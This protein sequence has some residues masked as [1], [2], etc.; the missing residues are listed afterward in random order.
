[1]VFRQQHFD[2][3]QISALFGQLSLLLRSGLSVPD[4][5]ALL[6][7]D[8]APLQQSVCRRMLT[9][10]ESAEN[11]ATAMRQCD[12][13]PEYACQMVSLSELSGNTDDVLEALSEHYAREAEIAESLRSAVIYPAVMICM[14]AAV[15]AVI[16]TKVLPV[17]D[18]VFAQMGGGLTG[19]SYRLLQFGQRLEQSA[20]LL[21]LL[22]LLLMCTIIL[23][24]KTP[25]FHPFGQKL[26]CSI[27]AVR[28]LQR[29]IDAGRFADGLSISLASGLSLEESLQLSAGLLSDQDLRLHA[30]KCLESFQNGA[31][32]S[33]ALADCCIFSNIHAK[34]IDI[35]CRTGSPEKVLR[36]IARQNFEESDAQI[37]RMIGI[38]EP[39]IVAVLCCVVG[40]ILLSVML[41]LLGILSGLS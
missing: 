36:K 4:S 39:S 15:V 6:A 35:G 1:M 31:S 17:F 34:M 8:S 22:L 25:K 24:R 21:I 3:V 20:S 2:A 26:L 13:F 7:E 5:I 11:L 23:I 33:E 38:L 19:L 14:M 10:L 32:F 12:V 37:C 18:Q 41:P 29:R 30:A 28:R 40:L 27:P 9:V 16:I